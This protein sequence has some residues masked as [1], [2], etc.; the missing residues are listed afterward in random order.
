MTLTPT[1]KLHPFSVALLRLKSLLLWKGEPKVTS[2]RTTSNRPRQR[3]T[4]AAPWPAGRQH[5]A[6]ATGKSTPSCCPRTTSGTTCRSSCGCWWSTSG[7]GERWA[8][9]RGAVGGERVQEAQR[10]A[11]VMSCPCTAQ[12][13]GPAWVSDSCWS[14]C[15]EPQT[16]GLGEIPS[17]C[18]RCL[19]SGVRT[20][21]TVL[22]L[23]VF[24]VVTITRL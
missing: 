20:A 10:R 4:A 24:T 8:G 19:V 21:F 17:L 15:V 13:W 11:V 2:P 23:S 5:G 18:A 9:E 12:L 1:A 6:G 16:E 22:G 3:H 7:R 14:P